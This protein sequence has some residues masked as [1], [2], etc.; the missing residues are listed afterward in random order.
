MRWR[1]DI[2]AHD[3]AQLRHEVGITGELEA[4]H[5]VWGEPVRRPDALHRGDAH[6]DSLGHGGSRPV[7][8]FVWRLGR[9][10][11]HDLVDDL[12]A[13]RRDPRGAGLVLQETVDA[14]FGEALLPAP[15]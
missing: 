7:R 14:R 4:A 6:S 12:L 10:E 2:E 8:R 9:G 13:K 1:I 3:V 11:R 15:D 5:A